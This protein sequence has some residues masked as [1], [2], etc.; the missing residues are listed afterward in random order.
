MNNQIFV[1]KVLYIKEELRKKNWI[2]L[3]HLIRKFLISRG[4]SYNFICL[5]KFK[6]SV[7]LNFAFRLFYDMITFYYD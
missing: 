5:I 4:W 2:S 1:E 3:Y 7:Y 6:L